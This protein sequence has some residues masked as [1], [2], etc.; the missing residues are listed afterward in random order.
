MKVVYSPNPSIEV[1][2]LVKF[3]DTECL[4]VLDDMNMDFPIRLVDI[5]NCK[6]V[7]GFSSL[8]SVSPMV[9]LICKADDLSLMVGNNE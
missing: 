8:H 3:R 7:G 1:G 4:V 5:S 6:R 9:Q 2:D